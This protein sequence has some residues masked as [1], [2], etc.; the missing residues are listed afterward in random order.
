M[1]ITPGLV[2]G[3]G[4]RLAAR[5][6]VQSLTTMSEDPRGKSFATRLDSL[7][8]DMQHGS[9]RA[10]RMFSARAVST[11]P[12]SSNCAFGDHNGR[13]TSAGEQ[14]GN[15]TRDSKIDPEGKL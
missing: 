1:R 7:H 4:G 9:F 3:R 2:E 11:A 15:D 13:V 10:L 12:C 8:R 14:S 5:S 6:V